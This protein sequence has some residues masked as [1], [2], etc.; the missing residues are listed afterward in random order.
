MDGVAGGGASQPKR[1]SSV[2]PT[3]TDGIAGCAGSNISKGTT[4]AVEQGGAGAERAAGGVLVLAAT[5]RRDMLDSALLRPGRLHESVEFGMPEKEDR[6]G[7]LRVHTR[8][9]PLAAGVDLER[10][11]RDDVSGG[12]SCADLEVRKVPGLF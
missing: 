4:G 7:V 10:L 1:S 2:S 6:E 12:L 5:S 11:S 8:R 3:D 9:L